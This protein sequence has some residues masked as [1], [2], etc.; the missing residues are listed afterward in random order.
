VVTVVLVGIVCCVI[1]WTFVPPVVVFPWFALASALLLGLGVV[2]SV[3]G[4]IGWFGFRSLRITTIAPAV[5]LVTAALVMLSVPST[6]AFAVS[7]PSL[8]AASAQCVQSWNDHWIGVYRVWRVQPVDGGCLFYIEGGLIDSIGLAYLPDGAPHL[9]KPRR[10]GD[11]GYEHYNGD[12]YRFVQ[13][14]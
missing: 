7:K 4:L 11:I 14:F 8:V 10:D 6:V 12:W 5:V 13:R 3:L 1:V 9:G 2:W